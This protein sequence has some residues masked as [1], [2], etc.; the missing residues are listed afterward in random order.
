MAV[1]SAVRSRARLGR[2]MVGPADIGMAGLLRLSG[3]DADGLGMPLIT[4][5][6]ISVIAPASDTSVLR[7][8]MSE[9]C[10]LGVMRGDALLGVNTAGCCI[11]K[12]K[13]SSGANHVGRAS[14]QKSLG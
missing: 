4:G 5:D 14:R 2:L 13:R 12:T 1:R 7:A 11:E 3:P 10:R 9:P 8:P 6:G